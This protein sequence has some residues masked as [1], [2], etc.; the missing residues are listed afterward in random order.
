[1][2][3]PSVEQLVSILQE[4]IKYLPEEYS[5]HLRQTIAFISEHKHKDIRE[6]KVWVQELIPY[7]E[8]FE[9]PD[10]KNI[11]KS[12]NQI[13]IYLDENRIGKIEIKG[14]PSNVVHFE[15]SNAIYRIVYSLHHQTTKEEDVGDVDAIAIELANSEYNTKQDANITFHYL[16]KSIG[17]IGIIEAAKKKGF[18]VFLIDVSTKQNL[19]LNLT[20]GLKCVEATTGLFVLSSLFKDIGKKLT[21][22]DFLRISAKTG[23]SIWSLLHLEE[24][25]HNLIKGKNPQYISTRL[26]ELSHPETVAIILTLRNHIWAQK[27]ETI[28]KTLSTKRKP[29]IALIIGKGHTGVERALAKD[30]EERLEIIRTLMLGSKTK[31]EAT[32]ARF[33]FINGRWETQIFFDPEMIKE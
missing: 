11:L 6:V 5:E 20:F 7:L 28:T 18:P 17:N 1:M 21:R 3:N 2:S 32:I 25:V 33:D 14:F 29:I 22:R 4:I 9:F 10:K 19:F 26:L 31:E 12:L 24:T 15:T 13:V 8:Q 16:S 23:F 27:L 30:E